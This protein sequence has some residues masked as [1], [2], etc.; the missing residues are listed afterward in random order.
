MAT[1]TPPPRR[2]TQRAT[3]TEDAALVLVQG[4]TQPQEQAPAKPARKR[5]STQARKPKA[6][7]RKKRQATRSRP[8]FDGVDL[9]VE[10][11]REVDTI[12][13]A[14]AGAEHAEEALPVLLELDEILKSRGWVTS[15]V[16]AVGMPSWDYPLGDDDF[17][18]TFIGWT[19]HDPARSWRDGSPVFDVDLVEHGGRIEHTLY[20]TFDELLPRLD[21]IEASRPPVD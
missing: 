17:D 12:E 20:L 4:D 9:L 5:A 6:A 14:A 21:E 16:N 1:R 18:S 13:E 19:A 7:R 8:A 3:P 2:T 10:M 15:T 11:P